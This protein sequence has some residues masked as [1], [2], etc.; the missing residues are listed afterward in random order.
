MSPAKKYE[1]PIVN[2]E[3]H[4][5]ESVVSSN[6]SPNLSKNAVNPLSSSSSVCCLMRGCRSESEE[7]F[8]SRLI[9][10]RKLRR[11]DGVSGGGGRDDSMVRRD[12][13][14]R[15]ETDYDVSAPFER[16]R[17]RND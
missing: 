16:K 10:C 9:I 5:R 2:A 1:A 13:A 3:I 17:R 7:N 11:M 4:N 8:G 15:R 6:P 12:P 14:T